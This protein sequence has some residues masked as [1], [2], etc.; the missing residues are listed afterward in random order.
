MLFT[1][2]SHIPSYFV[3]NPSAEC[4]LGGRWFDASESAAW[5]R[6]SCRWQS[7][8]SADQ[9]PLRLSN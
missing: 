8:R 4:D 6:D 3:E 5:A 2:R 7:Q 1:V 9:P